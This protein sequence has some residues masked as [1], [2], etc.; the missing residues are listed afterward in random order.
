MD[1]H[2]K[3]TH[4]RFPCLLELRVKAPSMKGKVFA[5]LMLDVGMGGAML[6]VKGSATGPIL[7]L[8]FNLAGKEVEIKARIARAAG[9]DKTRP[10]H[11]L[12]GV[13]FETDLSN[14]HHLRAIIDKARLSR[15]AEELPRDYW[16]L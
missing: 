6:S 8:N 3:R 16:R 5:A 7:L 2:S 15:P 14:Q 12:Y 10:R 9:P 13:A 4:A 1:G 11:Y